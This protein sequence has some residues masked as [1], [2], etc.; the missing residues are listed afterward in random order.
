[1]IGERM[2]LR[3]CNIL[4][5]A[6]AAVAGFA[7]LT[8]A[9][10]AEASGYAQGL[11][12][13]PS[14]GVTGALT[15]RPDVPEA[16]YFNPAGFAIQDEWGLGAG[17]SALFPL[18]Q[19]EGDDGERTRAEVDGAFPPYL[20][21]FGRY[22]DFALGISA[23]VPYGSSLQWPE[24]W[25]GRFEA[26]ATSIRAMEAA[27]SVAWRA[28]DWLAVGAG[29]RLVWADVGFE[30]FQDVAREG[31][32]A[33][34]R[35][36]ASTPGLGAQAG[37]WVAP[38]DLWSFGASWRS[39][40]DLNFEGMAHFDDV[41]PEMEPNMHDTPASTQMVLPHRLA[42]GVAYEIMANGIVSLDLEYSLWSSY[43]NFEVQFASDEV[44]DIVEDR[45]WNNTISMRVGTEFIS[46]LDG[47]AIRTGLAYEPS[48]APRE[49]LT[50][51]QP[52]TDR[53]ITSLGFGYSPFDGVEI[54]AAYNFSI[55][56]RT[57]SADE[58]L[59]GAY[60][61]FIHAFTLGVHARPGWEE[62]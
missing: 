36:D 23:G 16:G 30:R 18:V 15:A 25:E 13:A 8:V 5:A 24:D 39:A 4:P 49:T 3:L 17:G 50:A 58:G 42:V 1:M 22:Q 7:I 46:P 38:H 12:G 43:D 44:D 35:L 27:P 57:A 14:A 2:K 40:V 52:A 54:D 20:H 33:H 37:A 31:E 61:G 53:T 21:A 48:P 60:D 51:A 26:T 62:D 56:T 11:Q 6:V 47:L 28:T 34:V 41:P 9:E 10:T 45:D 32:E 59:S 55:F 19:H 29:P